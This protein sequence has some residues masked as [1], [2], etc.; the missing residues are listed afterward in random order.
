MSNESDRNEGAAEEMGGK[1]KKGLGKLLGDEQMEAEGRAK[2]LKGRVE[3]EDAKADERARGALEEAAGAIKNRIGKLVDNEQMAAEGK[4]KELRG[5]NRQK[6][7][8]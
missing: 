2:E 7:N 6:A 8:Q 4:A 1:L 5:E 3:Q